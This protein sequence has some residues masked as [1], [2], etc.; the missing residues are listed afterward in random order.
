MPH[1]PCA[2]RQIKSRIEFSEATKDLGAEH[3]C[4]II[5][6]RGACRTTVTKL[7]S[8]LPILRLEGASN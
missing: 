5:T 7:S 4:G 2:P 8:D 1:G 3:G 6:T